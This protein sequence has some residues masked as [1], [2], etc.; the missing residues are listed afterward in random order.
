MN[1]I[2]DQIVHLE[3]ESDALNDVG[4]KALFFKHRNGNAM[5][6]VVGVE[7]YDHLEKVM[8][9]FEDV[10]NSIGGIVIEQV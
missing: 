10:A 9:R 8:D 3:E 6:Y 4:L 5:H 7:I 1:A 2:A